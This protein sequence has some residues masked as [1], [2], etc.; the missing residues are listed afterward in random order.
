MKESF[1]CKTVSIDAKG[2]V[3]EAYGIFLFFAH[4]SSGLNFSTEDTIGTIAS[5][6]AIV[7]NDFSDFNKPDKAWIATY[8]NSLFYL[9]RG[10]ISM[11]RISIP[12]YFE[13]VYDEPLPTRTILAPTLI[14]QSIVGMETIR[15]LIPRIQN[16][17]YEFRGNINIL[18]DGEIPSIIDDLTYLRTVY[19]AAPKNANI[20]VSDNVITII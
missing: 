1:N 6:D 4:S 7:S 5:A 10:S 20:T 3:K 2:K 16:V 12:V 14:P 17:P 8:G 19:I 15:F 9:M 18:Y 13:N 11:K